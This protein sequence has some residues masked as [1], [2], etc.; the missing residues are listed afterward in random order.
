MA[1]PALTLL[2]SYAQKSNP[3]TLPSSVL[4]SHT[5]TTLTIF[6]CY[7]KSI[8]HFLILPRPS[9]S[10]N[11]FE[12]ATLRTLLKKKDREKARE[13]IY[14]LR[15]EAQKLKKDIE[16]E[17]MDRYGFVWEVWTG[18]HAVQSME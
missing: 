5:P 11:V 1:P 9:S 8:F 4:Y 3:S 17:M 18:F 14:G 16:E 13:V 10:V 7:P 15:D 6:D 2:R 12:L